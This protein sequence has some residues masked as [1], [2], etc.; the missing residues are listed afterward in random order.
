VAF[1]GM[2]QESNEKKARRIY[3]QGLI[4]VASLALRDAIQSL[5]DFV[6]PDRSSQILAMFT[7]AAFVFVVTVVVV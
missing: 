1:V 4:Y 3:S 2:E 5:I 6:V 7:V